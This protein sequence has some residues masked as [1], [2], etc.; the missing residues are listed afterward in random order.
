MESY[1][2][3]RLWNEIF[4]TAQQQLGVPAGF[5]KATVLVDSILAAF[6]MDEILWELR[7]YSAGLSCGRRGLLFSFIKKFASDESIVLPD[8][9]QVTNTTHFMHSYSK[10]CV[11]TCHRRR[12]SSIGCMS[13]L[14]PIE[15]D[16][17]ANERAISSVQADKEREARYGHDGTC[18]A[19]PGLVP[20]AMDAFNHVMPKANHIDMQLPD[21][22]P[23]AADLLQLPTGNVTEAGVRL[24]IAVGL[25][26][27]EALLRGIGRVPL[28]NQMEDAA[29][30]EVSCAQ[31]WQ[32]VHHHAKLDD[33]RKVTVEFV[34]ETI[35]AELTSVKPQ[36]GME[37]YRAY[38]RAAELMREIVRAEGFTEFLASTA[39]PRIIEREH[40]PMI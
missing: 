19:H 29:T 16:P 33:G 13:S 38:M 28:F 40:Y 3:A 21:F 14:I 12:V 31:L 27:V 20:V 17:V 30:A 34:E 15:D 39:Y 25:G 24:N 23:T 32:W 5:I 35:K 10:L 1:L 26:Y 8:R 36:V 7:E 9:A 11:K 6:E 22:N 4:L 37:R 2:E 18:V